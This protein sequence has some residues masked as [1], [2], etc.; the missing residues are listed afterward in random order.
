MEKPVVIMNFSG[1]YEK[2][3]FYKDIDYQWLDLRNIR[4]TNCYC[5]E[6]AQSRLKEILKG[7]TPYGI[8]FIDSG[9]YHYVTKLWT[10]K[11]SRPFSLIL[12][13][14]HT[15]LQPPAFGDILSCG[16]WVKVMLDTC[17][18][19]VRVYLI[20]MPEKNCYFGGQEKRKK[21]IWISEE[22]VLQEK[23]WKRTFLSSLTE[24]VY[25]SVDKDLLSEET[26]K[27]NWDQGSITIDKLEEML[28]A[29]LNNCSVIGMDVCGEYI[30]KEYDRTIERKCA[31]RYYKAHDIVNKLLLE[32][33]L[34]TENALLRKFN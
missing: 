17:P 8:H 24:P 6:A 12:F 28:E 11:I 20:G 9:N 29:V 1:I 32:Q 27:T 23:N 30:N 15:D 33:Y 31:E 34:N 19:L 22:E 3:N 10:E 18:N 26:V 16:S 21:L 5:D 13:D 14:H 25:I 7:Y 2:E 4:G